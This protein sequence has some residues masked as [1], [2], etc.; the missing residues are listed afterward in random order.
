MD[1]KILALVFAIVNIPFIAMLLFIPESPAFYVSKMKMEEAQKQLRRLRGN[2]WDVVKESL[3]IKK[4][5]KGDGDSKKSSTVRDFFHPHVLKPVT[6][7]TF[8][9]FFFQLSGIN[10][11]LIFGPVVFSEVTD[12]DAFTANI[13]LGLALFASN[14]LTL[15]I[16]GKCPR[17]IML[18]VSSL[19]CAVTL[20]VMGVSYEVRD[21]EA[22]C[23]NISAKLGPATNLTAEEAAAACSYNVDWLP[24]LDSMIFIFVFSLGYGSMVWITVVEML[25]ASIRTFTN[26]YVRKNIFVTSHLS[27]YNNNNNAQVDGGLGGSAVVRH[28]LHLPVPDGRRVRPDRL[29]DIRRHFFC[30][31]FVHRNLCT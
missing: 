27:T 5:L 7:A 26:G 3:E 16:A 11:M 25:P 4:N 8:L 18:L 9:L 20:A 24:V 12:I 2:S 30:W 17:R 22:E 10:L 13:L 14:T 19:G 23:R 15:F 6:I 1:Y 21:W 29:L 28:H 31:V